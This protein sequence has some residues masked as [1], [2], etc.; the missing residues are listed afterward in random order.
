MLGQQLLNGLLLGSSYAL[1]AVGYTL[2][3]GVLK[4]LNLAHGQVFMLAGYLGLVVLS[5]SAAPIWVAIAAAMAGAGLISIVLEQTCFRFTDR[6]RNELAPVLST[7]GFGLML[8]E[9][10]TRV[11]GSSPR[12][13]PAAVSLPDF[14]VGALL[15]SSVQVVGLGL[16][17]ALMACSAGSSCAPRPAGRCVPSPSRPRSRSCSASTP[18]VWSP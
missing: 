15:V 9:L 14:R 17:L 18:G 11:W 8:Q 5:T 6:E 7:V 1:V 4:L 10:A 13:I 2:V 3:F 16:A 12:P